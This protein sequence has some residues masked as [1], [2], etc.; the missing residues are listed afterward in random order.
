MRLENSIDEN[1]N[2]ENSEAINK[3]D[4]LI[5]KIFNLRKEEIQ[6]HKNTL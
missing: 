3:I 5:Y 6:I 2:K 1:F 4:K